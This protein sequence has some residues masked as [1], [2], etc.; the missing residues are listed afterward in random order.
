MSGR[1]GLERLQGL[2]EA[3]LFVNAAPS[4]C[5]LSLT[6]HPAPLALPEGETVC[7]TGELHVS[8]L[9]SGFTLQLRGA[10]LRVWPARGEAQ[11]Y[12]GNVEACSAGEQRDFFLLALLM[13]LRPAGR[14]GLHA[15][16]LTLGGHG[17]G[18][19]GLLIIGPSGAGKTTL[20]LRLH[21][22]G[23][24]ALSDDAV[25]LEPGVSGVRVHAL[26]RDFA[27]TERTLERLRTDYT[28]LAAE[29][30][31]KQL[32][33]LTHESEAGTCVPTALLF[34]QLSTTFNSSLEPLPKAQAL[35]LAAQQSAGI[36][37]DPDVSQRQ[38][39]ALRD[40]IAQTRTYR[41]FAGYDVLEAPA[42]VSELLART[43]DEASEPVGASRG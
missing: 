14:Y 6:L 43:L 25:L 4:E 33:R 22:A 1:A 5:A 12:L 21:E 23:W 30:N 35:I 16:A 24:R 17:L 31:G 15:N 39:S 41:L 29:P 26:R 42:R 40:L 38:L 18:G 37:T 11:L 2:L 19:H 13:L 9:T 3:H 28:H 7:R 32:V 20:S 10:G 27:C 8:R 34:P 36:M